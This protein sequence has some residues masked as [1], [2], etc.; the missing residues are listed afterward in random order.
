V[1]EVPLVL[2]LGDV[3][4]L[5]DAGGLAAAAGVRGPFAIVVVHNDGG[6]LFERLPL[7]RDDALAAERE[8]LFVAAHGRAFDGLAAT[9]GL[10]YARVDTPAAL[11]EALARAL[12]AERAVLIE[13]RVALGGST[14]RAELLAAVAQAG[15]AALARQQ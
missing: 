9:W 1:L 13:A 12:A 7:G 10:G 8:R 6:R 11:R 3:A 14:L 5:H 15:V 2:L 4:L